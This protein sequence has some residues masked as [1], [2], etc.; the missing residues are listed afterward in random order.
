M[1]DF[2]DL[3]YGSVELADALVLLFRG[4]SDFGDQLI[5]LAYPL[6]DLLEDAEH[7][8][9]DFD[10]LGG[11]AHGPFDFARG[12]LGGLRTALGEAANF[13]GDNGKPHARLTSAGG[14][15]GS[16]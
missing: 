10:A 1:D 7:L 5:N 4:L 8:L 11:L 12:F 16:V 2:V 13:V 9:A 14:L 3:A 15:D 6:H